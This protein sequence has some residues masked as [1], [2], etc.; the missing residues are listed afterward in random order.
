MQ[1]AALV[2]TTSLLILVL[3]LKSQT[4]E[5]TPPPAP[6]VPPAI[7]EPPRAAPAFVKTYEE[8]MAVRD[9]KVLVVF[10]ADWC[11]YC[12]LLKE[13]LVKSD[14]KGRLVCVV[15][16][17]ARPELKKKHQVRSLPT[18]V[19]VENGKETARKVG[20]IGPDYDS[21]LERNK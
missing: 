7:Q 14:L 20:F 8:A 6:Q 4:R 1:K 3:F 5:E 19:I 12:T 21:W 2:V 11:H 18:S 9:A 16:T 17:D 15:D 13:H 10:G